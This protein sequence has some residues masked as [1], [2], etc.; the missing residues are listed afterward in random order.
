MM[1]NMKYLTGFP[2]FPLIIYWLSPSC[3]TT[4]RYGGDYCLLKYFDYFCI[5]YNVL[6]TAFI[7]AFI[8]GD[9]FSV[10]SL[11]VLC[12]LFY[13]LQLVNSLNIAWEIALLLNSMPDQYSLLISSNLTIFIQPNSI[14]YIMS[15]IM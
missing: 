13:L 3:I 2:A 8:F 14:T 11:S 1:A 6:A 5:L 15:K 7:S 4:T 10:S 9:I 12:L